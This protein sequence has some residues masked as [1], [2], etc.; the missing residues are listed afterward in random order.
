MSNLDDISKELEA[1]E[2]EGGS[3]DDDYFEEVLRTELEMPTDDD[4]DAGADASDKSVADD[5]KEA[6]KEPEESVESLR[7]KLAEVEAAKARLEKD[8]KGK[9]S[10]VVKSRQE[11]S[12]LKAELDGLKSAVTSLLEKRDNALKQEVEEK[13]SLFEETRKTIAFDENDNAYVDL[14]DVKDKIEAETRSTKQELAAL[15]AEREAEKMK[16]TFNENIRSLISEDQERFTPA[17]DV[18]KEAY[19]DLNDAVIAMQHRL[20]IMGE[21]GA[22]EQDEALDLLEGSEELKMFS[23]AHPGIDPT[24]IARAFNSKVDFRTTLRDIAN[25]KS[26][27]TNAGDKS[28]QVKLD[29]RIK[30]AK[31]KPGSLASAENQ[32]GSEASLIDRITQLGTDDILDMSDSEAERIEAMLEREALK[33]E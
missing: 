10:D 6:T 12:Q 3:T 32:A 14:K 15:R 1:V 27:G 16:E 23:E 28:A 25:V 19:K 9:L 31:N 17:Y 20:G 18:L 29:E 2:L 33:G 26:F 7:A 8:A 13:P 30:Q 22:I 24:R 5:Q 11:R 21:D 4:T